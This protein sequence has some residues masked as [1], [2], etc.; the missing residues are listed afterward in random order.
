L[1]LRFLIINPERE[2]DRK[3]TW[4]KKRNIQSKKQC[5]IGQSKV[6]W[7]KIE[8]RFFTFLL[9]FEVFF[10]KNPKGQ[11]CWTC[12]V[13][14]HCI[15]VDLFFFGDNDLYLTKVLGMK[16]AAHWRLLKR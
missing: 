10:F 9:M 6:F 8:T 5:C 4:R 13:G 15:F 14:R 7:K 12:A 1:K 11:P 2:K 3:G 16:K